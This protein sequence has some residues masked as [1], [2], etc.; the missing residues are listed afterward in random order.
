MALLRGVNIGGHHKISMADVSME[1]V[2]MGFE[3]VITILNSGNLIFDASSGD[4]SELETEI[5]Q[6]LG[7]I[8]GFPV[9]SIIRKADEIN[10]IIE[11]DPFKG[12]EVSSSIQLYVTFLKQMPERK[13]ELPWISGDGYFR[14]TGI[15]GRTVFSV[16][17]LSVTTTTK[18]MNSLEL[19][20]GKN[21]TTRNWKTLLKIGDK[22]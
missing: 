1:L 22:L 8:A 16:V 19:L 15:Q 10:K 9:P 18:G 17:D 5:S 11:S 12:I 14:L 13:I 7:K 3:N 6:N 4:G 21:I 2:R 20:F